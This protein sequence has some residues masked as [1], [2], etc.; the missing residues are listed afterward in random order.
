M[1]CYLG[2]GGDFFQPATDGLVLSVS[3]HYFDKNT[4]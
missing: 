4:K 2:S 1:R 3:A